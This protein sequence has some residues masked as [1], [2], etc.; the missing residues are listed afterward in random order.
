MNRNLN[1][2]A[3]LFILI[4]CGQVSNKDEAYNQD[5]YDFMKLVINEQELNLS[6]G[7][8]IEPESSFDLNKSDEENFKSLLSELESKDKTKITDSINWT[9]E[10]NSKNLLS[11]LTKQDISGMIKQKEKLK[12][13][14]WNNNQLG[15]NLSNKNNWYSFSVP[16]FSEDKSKAVMM[17]RDLCSGLCGGGKTILFTKKNEKW[18]SNTG[19][20]WLH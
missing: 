2:L 15:F 3:I 18:T 8:I 6:Y 9:V 16:L 7:L 5:I 12:V 17:I 1:I 14:K 13:F 19:M 11:D 4:S 10:L 20:I